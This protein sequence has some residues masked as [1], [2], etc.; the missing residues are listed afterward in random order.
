[1][2]LVPDEDKITHEIY[3]DD[4]LDAQDMID[5]F[6]IDADYEKNDLE[7][8]EIKTEILGETQQAAQNEEELNEEEAA[9]MEE[10]NNV[11]SLSLINRK[12]YMISQK[13]I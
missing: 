10:N 3:I 11:F 6:H 1:L 2:D 12:K 5:V 7:W 4:Q 9:D 8:Q 13:Q